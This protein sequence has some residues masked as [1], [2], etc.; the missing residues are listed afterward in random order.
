MKKMN[1]VDGPHADKSEWIKLEF[2]MDLDNPTSKYSQQFAIFKDVFPE[3]WIKWVMDFCGIESL[4]IMKEPVDKTRIFCTL[5]KSK[6]LSYFEHHL[7]ER[8]EAEDSEIPDNELIEL[9]LRDIGLEYTPKRGI[10]MQ[11]YYMK[12]GL[13]MGLNTSV[14]N[15]VEEVE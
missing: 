3:D 15:F 7:R 12:L 14:H 13:Y 2:L 4:M 6:A 10:H 1:K 9:M 8:L 5:L 11:N